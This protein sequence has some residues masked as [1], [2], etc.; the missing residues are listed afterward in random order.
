MATAA[1]SFSGRILFLAADPAIVARQLAGED[2][3]LAGAGALRNDVSTDEITPSWI[4]LHADERLAGFVYLGL[5]CGD[6]FPFSEGS[7]ERAGFAV[8]VAGR[9][10]GKGSSREQSPFAER[11]AGIRLV[12]AQSFERIYR[13]NCT[14]LGIYTSTD[15]GLIERLRAGEAIPLEEFTRGHDPISAAII[16]MGGLGPFTSARLRGAAA[17][18][19]PVHAPRAM[20]L[21]EKLIAGAVV[22]EPGAGRTCAPDS[23]RERP[24]GTRVPGV[25]PGDGVFV[26]ANWRY[27][28]EYL[29]PMAATLFERAFGKD[30]RVRDP[31]SVL[32]FQEHLVFP[33][34]SAAQTGRGGALL[35]AAR[36]LGTRQ[37]AFCVRHSIRLH[38]M[39]PDRDGS[40]GICHSLMTERFALPGEIVAGTDSHTT[41]VGALG[42]L[43]F[44]VGASDMASAWLTG[45][46]RLVVPP[47]CR[48][49]LRGRLGAGVAAKD[50]VLHLL[51]L[52]F[53]RDGHAV[54]QVIEYCGEAVAAMSTDER[55]TLT[56][57]AAEIGGFTGI[58]AP[59][60]ETVR[61]LH[62]RRGVRF[63]L[64]PWMGGDPDAEY[65]HTLEIECATVRPMVARPGDPGDGVEIDAL[66]ET[67]PIDVAYCGSCTGAKREDL[68]RLHEVLEWG[69]ARGLRVASGVRFY[70][71][72][73]SLDV[74][75]HCEARGVLA[76]LRRAGVELVDPG[77]GAC[78]NAG[79][80]ASASAD[81]VTVSAQNRNF[82]G[83]SGPGQVWLASPA[84]VA[85]SAL[86]GRLTSFA[87]LSR[88]YGAPDG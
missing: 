19:A 24:G 88:Q 65:A 23:A 66:A 79:P 55:A 35:D 76:T 73:G 48:V 80:G 83:R 44:G 63:E 58:V 15:F 29:T 61:F 62:E 20:T 33:A 68:E 12:I 37:A 69:V 10:Y 81:E 52:P 57:M 86:A 38:G 25:R 59:D 5:K 39:L 4:C 8:I 67:I 78:V 2:L 40:E 6:A 82:P 72:F 26:R 87:A 85:A 49:V 51:R 16:R 18:P 74:R 84:T 43:A 22:S 42:C 28:H 41:H 53:V 31:G 45:D 32:A 56:N 1:V 9:R 60:A 34:W 30:A 27:S 7:V 77:C 70:V 36:A 64:A 21:A 14:N 13:A 71:Q 46:L 54:G 3:T 11:A 47:T 75:D 17:V 50:L